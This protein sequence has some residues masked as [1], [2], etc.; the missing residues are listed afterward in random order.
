MEHKFQ[1][2]YEI[3]IKPTF[4]LAFLQNY[5]PAFSFQGLNLMF[6][7]FAEI[8]SYNFLILFRNYNP[9]IPQMRDMF[10]LRTHLDFETCPY[11]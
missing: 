8:L 6:L 7:L 5:W 2:N 4:K 10:V 9:D 1:K 11:T 3:W